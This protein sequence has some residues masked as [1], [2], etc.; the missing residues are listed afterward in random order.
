MRV[1]ALI[2]T[3]LVFI[4]VYISIIRLIKK[5]SYYKR[6]LALYQQAKKVPSSVST[7]GDY[8]RLRKYRPYLKEFR[9]RML[10]LMLI[11]IGVFVAIYTALFIVTYYLMQYFV[12]WSVEVPVLIPFFTVVADGKMYTHPF[13]IILLVLALLIYPASRELKLE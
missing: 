8:R 3:V 7:K 9:R 6:I 13:V 5:T 1:F 12:G 2:F 4:A 11:N 10:T